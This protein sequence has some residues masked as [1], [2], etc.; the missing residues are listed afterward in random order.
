[1]SEPWIDE[2]NAVV[3][4]AF[5]IA[6]SPAADDIR[7]MTTMG[8]GSL[9]RAMLFGLVAALQG[10][11]APEPAEPVDEELARLRAENTQLRGILQLDDDQEPDEDADPEQLE[12]ANEELRLEAYGDPDADV[13]RVPVQTLDESAPAEAT[14]IC[15]RSTVAGSLW[16]MPS[17]MLNQ[18]T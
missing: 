11:D 5:A 13:P 3:E 7:Q 15:C 9:E 18:A 6:N 2:T 4:R 8:G 16:L 10:Q 12:L 1:M 17:R 14:V